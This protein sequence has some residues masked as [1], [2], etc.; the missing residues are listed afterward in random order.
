[1]AF[2]F[3]PGEESAEDGLKRIARSQ[4]ESGLD[5]LRHEELPQAEK[6]HQVR[7]RCKKMRGLLR[8]VR[9]AFGA[10]KA[11]NT[12]FRDA[13]RTLSGVRDRTAVLETLDEL[14]AHF[15]AELKKAALRPLRTRLEAAHARLDETEVE[16]KLADMRLVFR[17]ALDRVE[18]WTLDGDGAEA[19][20]K[21][22]AKTYKR[23]VKTMEAAAG[24]GEADA[25]H[26][27]RKRT[28]YH[29]YHL[30]LMRKAWPDVLGAY[31]DQAHALSS[32]LGDHHDMAVLTETA[33]D[34]L[35][36]EDETY[37]LLAG[38][39]HTRMTIIA[40]ETLSLGERLFCEDKSAFR[41]R[42]GAIWVAAVSDAA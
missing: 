14:E 8:L 5:E 7:K 24:S 27:W 23:A 36:E 20:S 40:D 13:A 33:R 32:L 37:E 16:E 15:D 38:L 22:A 2:S 34:H 30:R 17:E 28:K 26:D 10:Y 18:G 9:P 35:G 39:C 21:G 31:A 11:E 6:V 29:W 12:C 42:T 19:I 41:Q 25:F 1:M 4:I 3:R